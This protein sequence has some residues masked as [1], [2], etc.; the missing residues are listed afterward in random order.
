MDLPIYEIT[1]GDWDMG[2]FATSLVDKPATES[3]FMY[4]S[5]TEITKWLFAD[6][7]KREV[8]GAVLVPDKLIYRNE[9]GKEFFVKFSSEIIKEL[10]EKMHDEGFNKFFTIAHELGAGNTVKFLESWIK[11]TE[12]DKSVALGLN[13]P[14]GT[15]FMKV[16]I[17]SDLVW[18]NIKEGKLNGFSIELDASMIKTNLQKQQMDFTKLLKNE[19]VSGEDTLRFND[20]KV[21]EVVVVMGEGA[22]PTFYNGTFSHEGFEYVVEDGNITT[23]TELSEDNTDDAEDAE[24]SVSE[25]KETITALNDKIDTFM[26]SVTTLFEGLK[27]TEDT[28]NIAETIDKLGDKL[29]EMKL[30]FKQTSASKEAEQADITVDAPAEFDVSNYRLASKWARKNK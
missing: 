2:I 5:K 3:D 11:E 18:S 13:E 12:E 19:V 21:D 4:M 17:E 30:E 9:H 14:L 15:L 28:P 26:A 29:E 6:E 8:V 27:P 22:E 10:N 24:P 23:I 16:K 1:L 20:L 7:E 25:L